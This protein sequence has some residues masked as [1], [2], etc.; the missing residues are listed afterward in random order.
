MFAKKLYCES[1]RIRF[2][3]YSQKQRRRALFCPVCG[4]SVDVTHYDPKKHKQGKKRHVQRMW[5]PE[6]ERELERLLRTTLRYKEIGVQM[7]R[8]VKSIGHKMD[9]LGWKRKEL[10]K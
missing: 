3:V 4:E 10:A 6:E 1:C 5:S 9:R 2:S 7:N 8:T